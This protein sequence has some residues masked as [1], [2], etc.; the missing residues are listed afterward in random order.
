LFRSCGRTANTHFALPLIIWPS[1]FE[2]LGNS[3]TLSKANSSPVPCGPHK[4][5]QLQGISLPIRGFNRTTKQ[6][7]LSVLVLASGWRLQ[8]RAL[9]CAAA[10]FDRVYVLGTKE[11]RPLALS[12]W[13][14]SFHQLRFEEGF[15]PGSI[16]FI[17]RLCEKLRIDWIIPSDARTTRFLTVAGNMLGPK[18]FPVPNT[19]V[20]DQLSDKGTFAGLCQSLDLATPRTGVFP[21]LGQVHERVREGSWDLPVVLKP[22]DREGSEGLVLLDSAATLGQI[23][24]LGYAPVLV[25]EYVAGRD[26]CAFYFCQNGRVEREALYHHGGHF[27]EFIEDHRVSSQCRKIIE[28]TNYSG[29]VGFDIRQ[30]DDGSFVFL[31]C[32]PRFWYNME[33]TMLAGANFVRAG[34]NT[35][36]QYTDLVGKVVI[37]PSGLLK[38]VRSAKTQPQI[39]L[40]VLAYLTADFPL[41]ITIGVSKALRILKTV[42]GTGS[43]VSRRVDK[44]KYRFSLMLVAT[45]A[46]SDSVASYLQQVS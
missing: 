2:R 46:A 41:M 24:D 36:E 4:L 43:L 18:S 25:Q 38:K 15:G 27:I 5:L 9:R 39:R 40:A 22:T 21:G 45:L 30:R 8:Y 3:R 14:H 33:L 13:C 28:A 7:Q 37:R 23:N 32:N 34:V 1:Q 17:R 44:A 26:I 20:F 19:A 6:G 12:L 29:V 10:C 11:A 42:A 31:E 16:S 35:N